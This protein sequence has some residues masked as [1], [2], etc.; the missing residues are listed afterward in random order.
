MIDTTIS[1]TAQ[2]WYSFLLAC[3][4]CQAPLPA[5]ASGCPRCGFAAEVLARPHGRQLDLRPRRPRPVE[6]R[7]ARAECLPAGA[8]LAKIET[9][10]PDIT[11]A[12]PQA[13]R[14]SSGL[15][16]A[17][18]PHLGAGARVLDLGC[19]SR[20]QE[21]CFA[22]LGCQYVGVDIDSPAADLLADAHA[23]PFV[24]GSFDLVF[25]YAV[26]EHLRSPLVA[27][28]EIERVLRPAGRYVGTVSQ[29]EPFH[30]SYY[31]HTAWALIA[32]VAEMPSLQ[33]A[34]LWAARDTLAALSSMG[35]YP[36]AIRLLLGWTATLDRRLP[37]LA[38]R[39]VGWPA[40]RKQ[41][42]A[43]H[44]AGSIGFV[45]EKAAA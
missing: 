14:D 40:K 6:I 8:A 33:I 26:L 20:D 44:R 35:G 9:G 28:R 17:V 36:R 27:I 7:L 39:R 13:D 37:L 45:I 5:P 1:D 29:G 11:Y 34:R 22:H 4:D 16:S 15:L 31:H 10:V 43:L 42:E 21:R 23:L 41:V 32:L 19:G 2:S 30:D 3:P 25:S 24:D 38:P 18:G 12:G